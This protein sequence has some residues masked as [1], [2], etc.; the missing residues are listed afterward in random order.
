M[1]ELTFHLS[2]PTFTLL[3]RAGLAGLYMTLKQLEKEKVTPAEGMQWDLNPRQVVLHWQGHDQKALEWLLNEAFQLNDGLIALRGLDSQSMRVDAQVIVHQGI[4]GT[5]LQHTSTHKAD[6]IIT[7]TF[8][9]EGEDAA[10][11]PVSY[12]K[13]VSYIY[14]SFA[15]S[16]CDAQGNFLRKPISVAGWLNPGAVVRH[17]AFSAD[18]SF[19]EAPENALVLLFAPIAC[20]YYILRSRLRDKRA[21]Y[22]LVVPEILDL[23]TYAQ[24]RQNTNLRNAAYQ[25]FYACGLGDAGLRFLTYETT[26]RLANIFPV[27]RCQVLTLGTVAWAT[28]QK[29][30]TDLYIV[31]ANAEVCYNYQV[32]QNFL[33]P[34][35]VQ[36]KEGTFLALSFASELITENLGRSQPWYAG[37]ADKVNSN[38]LFQRLAYE[39]GGLYQVVQKVQTDE[40]ERQFVQ[41][42]H[43]AI[44]YTYGQVAKNTKSGEDPNFDKVTVRLRTGLGRC[45]NAGSFREF[46]TDFWSRAGNLPTLKNHWQELMQFVM[47]ENQWKKSRDLAL[48]ALASYPGKEVMRQVL[49]EER[50]ED[51]IEQEPVQE[52]V[53]ELG[54]DD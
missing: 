23:Q 3:H 27:P 8:Q 11:T 16:L 44:Y 10:E 53:S 17:V 32:C 26:A 15:N 14:Q 40:R 43:E 13:L 51:D 2:N 50:T 9:F 54:W 1:Q 30:R 21:Q 47:Q 24:Y 38:E 45:K 37:I 19:E 22:A 20:Y 4:L 36:G 6:G 28:Q 48:L 18:T 5:F 39:R 46:I 31:N 25:D 41:T 42:C 12:K 52:Q 7:R 29:T 49:G 33:R 35:P 34:K